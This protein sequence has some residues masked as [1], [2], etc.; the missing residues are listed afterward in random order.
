MRQIE[1]ITQADR[2]LH[3]VEAEGL[4][5]RIMELALEATGARNGAIFLWDEQAEGLAVHFH[6]VNGV[7][8]KLP[9]VVLRPRRD[10]RPNGIA[11]WVIHNNRPYLCRDTL[12][13]E[14]YSPYFLE[15]RSVVAVPIPYQQRAIGV[16]S[17]SSQQ[18]D[19]F[20]ESSI[21][22]LT[23][24][25]ASAAKYLRRAQLYWSKQE[26]SR[27]PFLI[28]GLNP[29]W[30]EVERQIELVAPTDAPVLIQGESGTGKELV[31]NAIHFNSPR[32]ARPLVVVN[33]AAIPETLLESM[34][35]GHHQGAF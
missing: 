3:S 34:L 2:E 14:N 35:F 5:R 6:Y 22:Q 20:D 4:E 17:V 11:L 33:C 7:I 1:L 26:E 21:E 15:V 16:I 32:A 8:I 18:P 30:L 9:G 13:D 10:N 12:E 23:G 19:A 28:K 25:A 24:L 29:Q 27:R 31:A